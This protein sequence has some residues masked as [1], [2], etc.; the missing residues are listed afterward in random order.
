MNKNFYDFSAVSLQGKEVCMDVY[1]GKAVL[2][3]RPVNAA[4]LPSTKGWKHSTGNIRTK[5]WSSW[6]FRA[7]SLFA[8]S[9]GTKSPF[10]KGV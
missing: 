5:A 2:V 8:R 3:I 9:P 6:V 10:Q 7:T 4:C 1:R